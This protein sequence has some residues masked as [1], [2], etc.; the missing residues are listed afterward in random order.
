M[1]AEQT[2]AK[3]G[4]VL[5]RLRDSGKAS[6]KEKIQIISS[7]IKVPEVTIGENEFGLKVASN[8]TK[9][10]A[11]E[12]IYGAYKDYH[13]IGD[14]V[15]ATYARDIRQTDTGKTDER[16]FQESLA[17]LLV[18]EGLGRMGDYSK[19]IVNNSDHVDIITAF[20]ANDFKRAEN[21]VHSAYNRGLNY[22]DAVSAEL[23]KN[24]LPASK[25]KSGADFGAD[26]IFKFLGETYCAQ[27]KALKGVA[28]VKSV[29]EVL[30][31]IAQYGA[32]GAVVFSKQGFSEPAK[33]LAG[34]NGIALVTGTNIKSLVRQL[35]VMTIDE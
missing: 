15:L 32:N 31:A 12:R 11:V 26:I 23:N 28:G 34:T 5:K 33:E 35:A 22:E 6:A 20:A 29:Q 4:S 1:P 21:N 9:E 25:T 18:K 27:C 3:L 19:I 10:V 16:K 30:P 14:R 13:L 24:G 7:M 8:I 17:K 2:R